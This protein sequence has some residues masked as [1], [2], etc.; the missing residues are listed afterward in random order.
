MISKSESFQ[1]FQIWQSE[2]IE[3]ISEVFR[4]VGLGDEFYFVHLQETILWDA[5]MW[6][7]PL[8]A[9][10]SKMAIGKPC[11][12]RLKWE[13]QWKSYVYTYYIHGKCQLPH[14]MTGGYIYILS[15][16][17]GFLQLGT[18]KQP[19]THMHDFASVF[20]K[21][22]WRKN[23]V[24]KWKADVTQLM[25]PANAWLLRVVSDEHVQGIYIGKTVYMWRCDLPSR[26][27]KH[28]NK[29]NLILQAM[30]TLMC[31]MIEFYVARPC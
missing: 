30:M 8:V 27:I 18:Q 26:V 3:R 7:H 15:L 14:L 24:N 6:Y 16:Y 4:S 12:W 9:T 5:E 29:L 21:I 10:S 1:F 2:S 31:N 17:G 19:K 28:G 11:K 20:P 22:D 13:N 23:A 25:L